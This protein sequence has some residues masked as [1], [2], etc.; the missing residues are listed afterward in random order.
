M[1]YAWLIHARHNLDFCLKM[2]VQLQKWACP[3]QICKSG[4]EVAS[5][6]LNIMRYEI[7]NYH[8]FW[9]FAAK[10]EENSA[11]T[12]IFLE[13]Y[14]SQKQWL[15]KSGTLQWLL[16]IWHEIKYRWYSQL[17][18]SSRMEGGRDFYQKLKN[19]KLWRS[20]CE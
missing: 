1:I 6:C 4:S 20:F 2:G 7:P 9:F 17:H 8:L 16:V 19:S 14:H 5:K 11:D 3:L 12:I 13:Q 15:K 18:P 10:W